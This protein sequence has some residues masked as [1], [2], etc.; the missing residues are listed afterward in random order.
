MVNSERQGRGRS[1]HYTTLG[2]GLSIGKMHK[3]MRVDFST[4][5]FKLNPARSL[6]R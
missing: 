3:K 4:L 2:V 5:I 6:L 1:A